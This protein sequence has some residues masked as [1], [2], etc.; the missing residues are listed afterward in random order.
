MKGKVTPIQGMIFADPNGLLGADGGLGFGWKDIDIA[1]I[2]LQWRKSPTLTLRA[3][4]S[5][6]TEL[7]DSGQAL[8]NILAPATIRDHFSFGG[9]WTMDDSNKLNFA[10]TRALKETI[11]GSNPIFTP[12]QTGS[13]SMEQVELEVSWSHFF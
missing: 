1:K 11:E 4:Y 13:V 8:F 7:F 2:G 9:T 3:G 10:F 12:G 5:H 6:T